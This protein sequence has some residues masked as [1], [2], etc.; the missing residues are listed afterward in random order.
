MYLYI[1]KLLITYQLNRENPFRRITKH[2]YL[3]QTEQ[4][5]RLVAEFE[6]GCRRSPDNSSLCKER[7]KGWTI[8]NKL[9]K[10]TMINWNLVKFLSISYGKNASS[11]V[12]LTIEISLLISPLRIFMISKIKFTLLLT[13]FHRKV[14]YCKCLI[15][16]YCHQNSVGHFSVAPV[17]SCIV[18][19]SV[20]WHNH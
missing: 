11:N 1:R 2:K 15:F 12:A 14:K 7:Q 4:H 18:V 19:A 9:S 5:I 3:Y 8:Y 16:F 20:V 13:N 10:I 6:R 17:L